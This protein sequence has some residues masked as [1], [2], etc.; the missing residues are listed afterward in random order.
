MF[1]GRTIYVIAPLQVGDDPLLV[2][3]HPAGE[4]GEQDQVGGHNAI[5]RSSVLPT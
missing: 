2:T 1:S 4:H 5:V 3:L